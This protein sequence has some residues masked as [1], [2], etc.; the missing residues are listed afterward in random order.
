MSRPQHLCNTPPTTCCQPC[1]FSN[2]MLQI[3]GPKVM[4][5]LAHAVRRSQPPFVLRHVQIDNDDA[6]A[7]YKKFD[8]KI[9]ETVEDYYKR[10]DPSSAYVLEKVIRE[11]A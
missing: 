8:F 2:H 4:A 11:T 7:F 10:V 6:I 3:I 1:L 5:P 9:A